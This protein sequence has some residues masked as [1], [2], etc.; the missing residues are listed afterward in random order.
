MEF[1]E[2]FDVITLW[3]VFEHI[4]GGKEYLRLIHK[5]LKKNGLLFL[6]VPSSN[7]LA[8]KIM[9]EKCRAFDGIEHVNMFNPKT[10]SLILEDTGFEIKEMTSIISE[11]AVLNNF[12]SY[13]HP[14]YGESLFGEDLLDSINA[15]LIH[16]NLLGYKIQC[17]AK[18]I[19]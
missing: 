18:K 4:P 15:D 16:K 6:Q 5:N 3:D 7:S 14:Y 2:S 8:A 12:L 17:V 13:E 9:R 1:E 19:I 11:I 10:L